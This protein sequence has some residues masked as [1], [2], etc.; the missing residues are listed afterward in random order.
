MK[1]ILPSSAFVPKLDPKTLLLTDIHPP[2]NHK[3]K[4][5]KSKLIQDSY[6]QCEDPKLAAEIFFDKASGVPFP[7]EDDFTENKIKKRIVR[8]SIWNTET[9][10]FMYN[11]THV[12][13]EWRTAEK[14]VWK[15]NKRGENETNPIIFK[16]S[17]S[18][19]KHLE[20]VFEFVN[21][22]EN[23]KGQCEQMAAAWCSIPAEKLSKATSHTLNLQGGS[24]EQSMKMEQ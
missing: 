21:Y 15:F 4:N 17:L 2:K 9:R 20:V 8:A 1:K 24:P 14:D 22:I 13:A 10:M 12:V 6:I 3:I 18:S 16:T 19:Y 11:T 23:R 5:R 7:E